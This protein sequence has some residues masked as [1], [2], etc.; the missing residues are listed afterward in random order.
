MSKR[1]R[2]RMRQLAGF[3]LHPDSNRISKTDEQLIK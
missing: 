2:R 1:L 3:L